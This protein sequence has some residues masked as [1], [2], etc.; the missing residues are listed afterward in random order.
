MCASGMAV[1]IPN[2]AASNTTSRLARCVPAWDWSTSGLP[3]PSCTPVG[4]QLPL[5]GDGS[6]M[7]FPTT[8]GTAGPL[9][10][11]GPWGG[12]SSRPPNPRFFLPLLLLH[13][14]AGQRRLVDVVW[15]PPALAGTASAAVTLRATPHLA[16]LALSSRCDRGAD[17]GER[18]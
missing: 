15:E 4:N 1:S 8:N 12:S 3:C 14:R 17:E 9:L 13:P 11:V 5:A 18:G 10:E 2:P 16:L 7:C 6:L